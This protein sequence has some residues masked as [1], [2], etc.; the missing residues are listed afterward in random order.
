MSAS[1]NYSFG[2]DFASLGIHSSSSSSRSGS[3]STLSTHEDF[4]SSLGTV[5]LATL[6]PGAVCP[7]CWELYPSNAS[8]HAR[9]AQTQTAQLFDT[10][11]MTSREN[12][13]AELWEDRPVRLSCSGA[14][15]VGEACMLGTS[16]FSKENNEQ[17]IEHTST[18][19]KGGKINASSQHQQPVHSIP[20]TPWKKPY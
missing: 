1:P 10:L 20:S 11:P 12:S 14:H 17:W 3:G 8:V 5:D 18:V 7:V 6:S 2:T 9:E 19:K 13:D 15:V 4:L 16:P